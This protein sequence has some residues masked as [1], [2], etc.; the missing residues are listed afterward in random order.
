MFRMALTVLENVSYFFIT[1]FTFITNQKI[2]EYIYILSLRIITLS[3][4]RLHMDLF[5]NELS[6]FQNKILE[7]AWSITVANLMTTLTNIWLNGVCK[8]CTISIY[9]KTKSVVC[10]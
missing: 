2:R 5:Y 4:R 1:S 10:M 8:A 7:E 3:K 9:P 6:N